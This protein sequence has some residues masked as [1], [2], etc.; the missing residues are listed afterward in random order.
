M[1][2]AVSD[3]GFSATLRGDQH[4]IVIHQ[5]VRDGRDNVLAPR[6]L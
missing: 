6:K 1:A 5:S 3:G 2:T 4:K